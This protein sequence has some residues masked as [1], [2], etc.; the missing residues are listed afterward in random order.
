MSDDILTVREAARRLR[1]TTKYVFD[2]IYS[3][4]FRGARKVQGRWAIPRAS[5]DDHRRGQRLRKA[6]SGKRLA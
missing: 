3:G 1:C 4:R 5:I 2:L 6:G